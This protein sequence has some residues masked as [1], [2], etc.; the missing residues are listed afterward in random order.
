MQ[1][2]IENSNKF[3]VED[4]PIMESATNALMLLSKMGKIHIVAE[5]ELISNAISIANIIVENF[6]KNNSTVEKIN[7][8]SEISPDD[9]KMISNIEIIVLKN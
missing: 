5:G 4:G 9:G 7:L 2:T 1:E 8:D 6:L 3:L